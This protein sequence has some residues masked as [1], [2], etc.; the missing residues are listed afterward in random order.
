MLGN[1]SF[2]AHHVA[3][4]YRARV[5]DA[6]RR[7]RVTLHMP[8]EMPTIDAIKRF[9]ALGHGVALLPA[10]ASKPSWRAATWCACRCRSWPSTGNCGWWCGDRASSRTPSRRFSRSLS[11]RPP[12]T[13]A[14][15]RLPGTTEALRAGDFVGHSSR[16]PRRLTSG[17]CH[18]CPPPASCASWAAFRI[19]RQFAHRSDR[20]TRR[21]APPH[22]D[23]PTVSH[24]ERSRSFPSTPRL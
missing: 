18:E 15:S 21:R 22:P 20:S 14:A 13:A 12:P 19:L 1:E 2:V 23:G 11:T 3:S 8:V 16:E 4:P 7:H 10:S 24:H 5:L 17:C 9:V 6:F